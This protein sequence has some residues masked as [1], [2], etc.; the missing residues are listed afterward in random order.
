MPS[1]PDD[2]QQWQIMAA[3]TATHP[4]LHEAAIE[5]ARE[6]STDAAADP[7]AFL[8]RKGFD[9]PADATVKVTQDD[10]ATD[11]PHGLE[12]SICITGL[13]GHHAACIVLQPPIDI[14]LT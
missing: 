5:L 10:A 3:H 6:A 14:I 7:K 8:V 9:L 4:K 13:P 11:S 12:I 1:P 2:F